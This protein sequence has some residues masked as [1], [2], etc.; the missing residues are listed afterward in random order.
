MEIRESDLFEKEYEN[1]LEITFAGKGICSNYKVVVRKN[2][3]VI[4]IELINKA[5]MF[6][7]KIY[8]VVKRFNPIGFEIQTTSYG[9]LDIE[10]ISKLIN[11]YEVAKQTVEELNRMFNF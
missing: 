5:D 2:P 11:S 7:P 1:E 3:L 9:S 6:T 10:E 4:N 8:T